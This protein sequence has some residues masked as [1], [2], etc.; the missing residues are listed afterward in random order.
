MRSPDSAT[1]KAARD[2]GLTAREV[3]IVQLVGLGLTNDEI[4][5]RLSISPATAKTHVRNAMRKLHTH[6]RA[7]LVALVHRLKLGE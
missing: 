7:Q 1:P 3:G 6:D 5:R 2:D 4:G